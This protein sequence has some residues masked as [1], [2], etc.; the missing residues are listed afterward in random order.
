MKRI[1]RDDDRRDPDIPR[2]AV[3]LPDSH[4]QALSALQHQRRRPPAGT[5]TC[6]AGIGRDRVSAIARRDRGV[7]VVPVPAGAA[8][9]EGGADQRTAGASK[10]KTAE[11]RARPAAAAAGPPA[12]QPQQHDTI[13]RSRRE[14]QEYGRDP[15]RRSVSTSVG[16]IRDGGRRAHMARVIAR[17][18]LS[19]GCRRSAALW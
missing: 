15:Q 19:S 7:D 1:D 8:P 14:S 13:G 18:T 10:L 2:K 12:R 5:L 16:C 9:G 11:I 17:S 6:P 3:E 4:H